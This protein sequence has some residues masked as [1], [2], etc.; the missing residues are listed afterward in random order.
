VPATEAPKA[1]A[2]PAKFHE[3]PALTELVKAGKLPP[4]DQRLPANP[5][6]AQVIESIGQYGGDLRWAVRVNSSAAMMRVLEYDALVRW[7]KKWTTVLSNVAESYTVND[8][9][10]Q[11]T[12]KLRKGLKWSD[13]SDFTAEDI[14]FY[15]EDIVSNKELTPAAP[16]WLVSGGK[17]VTVEMKDDYTI[18]F[19]FAVPNGLFI[20]NMA[21]TNGYVFTNAPKKW[22][23]RFMP[24]SNPD[25]E[26]VVKAVGAAN[27][28]AAVQQ[29]FNARFNFPD[30]PVLTPWILS[31]S[32]A[33][34][35]TR[36]V[37]NRNPYYFKVDA[38]GNQLPYIPKLTAVQSDDYQNLLLQAMNGDIDYA[39]EYLNTNQN[40][41]ILLQNKDKGKYSLQTELAVDA[42]SNSVQLNLCHKDQQK[43]EIYR[44]KDFRIG[45]S[46]AINRQEILDLVYISQGKPH[47][48][49]PLEDSE[50]YNKQLATQYLEYDVAKA[51][52]YLDKVL[53]KKDAE[54]FRLMPDGKRLQCIIQIDN[55][56]KDGTDSM[57]LVAKY[58][59]EVGVQTEVRVQERNQWY[60]EKAANDHD[61]TVYIAPGGRGLSVL[62]EPRQYFPLYEESNFAI[63]WAYWWT[64]VSKELAE[65]PTEPAKKQIELWQKVVASA[66][67]EDRI[68]YMKQL[69]QIAAD[70]F[71]VIGIS[72]RPDRY[73]VKA[74]SL[75]NVMDNMPDSWSYPNPAPQ[76]L[77]T[78]YFKA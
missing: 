37:A 28:Q 17:P 14:R 45:L 25:A 24:A 42:N 52:E 73:T 48:V 10:T 32:L 13:G 44:N 34:P 33:V 54:G 4:V 60:A 76:E 43:R 22:I 21:T 9:A 61:V 71:W 58:W 36:L 31:A 56:N 46:H 51:K 63:P 75:H 11:F 66:K 30:R 12:F 6:V 65:E 3:D 7:D 70:Q 78:W 77:Y 39:Y 55:S 40:K 68:T 57:Q 2:A 64:G 62:M 47:Q 59:K 8:D 35:T 26:A 5:Y 41:P 72:T 18:V 23:Q 19:K 53:P 49:A 1:A 15:V 69:L 29:I 38:S 50:F 67:H 16:T 20:Y 27:W 74:N